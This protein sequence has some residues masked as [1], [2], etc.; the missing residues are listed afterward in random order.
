MSKIYYV[1]GGA[2]S[3]KSSFAEK[4]AENYSDVGYIATAI[5]TD[6]EMEERINN[7]KSTRPKDWETYE[8][9]KDID[10][11]LKTSPCKTFLLDC[12]TIMTTNILMEFSLDGQGLDIKSEK[13]ISDKVLREI[14]NL[15]VAAKELDKT[16]I[17][18][19]NEVG[20]GIVPEG[21]LSRLFRDVS[22]RANQL[23]A[24]LCDEA[25]LLVSGI[26][27]KIKG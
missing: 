24:S 23:M 10:V 25:Y 22:G 27:I 20:M 26:P 12:L 17:V 8:T 11:V 15:V 1:T 18:V 9:Y 21:R 16:L 2:R 6:E 7:H 3:G 4:I 19:S 13:V 5:V 14:M